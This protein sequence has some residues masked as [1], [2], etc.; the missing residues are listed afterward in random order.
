MQT[1]APEL[2]LIEDDRDIREALAQALQ[3]EGY[4]VVVAE[5]GREGLQ[6]LQTTRAAASSL[7][8]LIIL[9]LMMPVMNGWEF[10]D[11][12]KKEADLSQI[13]VIVSSAHSQ[14]EQ[15]QTATQGLTFVRKPIDLDFLLR[16]IERKLG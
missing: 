12:V 1:D 8:S 6:R 5:N 10:L 16:Q 9:D 15:N 4:R 13:P 2:L 7:P 14:A 3:L 11:E